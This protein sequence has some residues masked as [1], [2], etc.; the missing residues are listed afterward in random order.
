MSEPEV[1]TLDGWDFFH[2]WS[3]QCGRCL[4]KDATPRHTCAAFPGGIPREIWTSAHDHREPWP[5]D[6]GLRFEPRQDAI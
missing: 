5:D 2:P 3:A 1:H 4:H 6:R